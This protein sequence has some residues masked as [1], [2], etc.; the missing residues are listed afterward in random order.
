[1]QNAD[2]G[3]AQ[4]ATLDDDGRVSTV[5]DSDYVGA[6]WSDVVSSNRCL[7][8]Y[9]SQTG[10]GAIN[11]ITY[12]RDLDKYFRG[13]N[14]KAIEFSRGWT[15][16]VSDGQ[17]ILFYNYSTRTVATGMMIVEQPPNNPPEFSFRE[18]HL[19]DVN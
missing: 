15:N 4:I 5:V 14:D 8:F 10:R 1:L 6:G 3:Q 7:L 2:T 9:D 13:G 17:G 19:I 18:D 12:D 16:L 11:E